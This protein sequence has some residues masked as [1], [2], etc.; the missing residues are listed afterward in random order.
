MK[1]DREEKQ[2]G[3]E[4][5]N[6]DVSKPN[7]AERAH[8]K[9]KIRKCKDK[10]AQIAS[11]ARKVK[12]G[13][14]R[15][16]EDA[17][18]STPH[19]TGRDH[20]KEKSRRST[21]KKGLGKKQKRHRTDKKHAASTDAEIGAAMENRLRQL[22]APHLDEWLASPRGRVAEDLERARR[23]N[24]E[25]QVSREAGETHETIPRPQ[26]S[27]GC[28]SNQPNG[29][30]Q[31][32]SKVAVAGPGAAADACALARSGSASSGTSIRE[33]NMNDYMLTSPR[34][35]KRIH[36]RGDD[37]Q[38]PAPSA[39]PPVPAGG[40]SLRNWLRRGAPAGLRGAPGG[41][42]TE[43][44]DAADAAKMEPV[45][46]FSCRRGRGGRSEGANPGGEAG[47]TLRAA[48]GDAYA[49]A[50]KGKAE[51][52]KQ[53]RAVHEAAHAQEEGQV[54]GPPMTVV[55]IARSAAATRQWPLILSGYKDLGLFLLFLATFS[56]VV[57]FQN[58]P[59]EAFASIAQIKAGVFG[60]DAQLEVAPC[61]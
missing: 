37:C 50:A 52:R 8:R 22:Q 48:A 20:E 25:V 24:S 38:P 51:A 35:A 31:D 3:V 58:R 41:G 23:N 45:T 12:D 53:T 17:D 33:D 55:D 29:D 6:G 57:Y 42:T 32:E 56:G 43:A 44:A 14:G 19:E 34:L 54:A 5:Q 7:E 2:S 27:T 18:V 4:K 28:M 21:D 60:A 26:P 40:E 49:H 16:K 9:K 61:D 15:E 13:D 11:T 10:G 59:K 1:K 30:E 46:T 47:S 36:Q 39:A